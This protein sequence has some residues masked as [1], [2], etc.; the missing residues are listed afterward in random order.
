M[1]VLALA[2][3]PYSFDVHWRWH[4][5]SSHTCVQ[6][7]FRIHTEQYN[8]IRPNDFV[9]VHNWLALHLSNQSECFSTPTN[10]K[11]ISNKFI[12]FNDI[13]FTCSYGSYVSYILSLLYFYYSLLPCISFSFLSVFVFA[14]KFFFFFAS[15]DSQVPSSTHLKSCYR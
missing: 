1:Y 12:Y 4:Y 7:H 2:A 3:S 9:H 10:I 13:C 11:N 14:C 6:L 15:V 5:Y 8:V